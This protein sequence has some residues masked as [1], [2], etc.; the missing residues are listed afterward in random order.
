[1]KNFETFKNE[2]ESLDSAQSVSSELG[3]L[4]TEVVLAEK[5]NLRS[6]QEQAWA[7]TRLREELRT[8]KTEQFAWRKF[9]LPAAGVLSMIVVLGWLL[10]SEHSL[11]TVETMGTDLYAK[12]FKSGGAEV[13]WVTGYAYIP[14]SYP[15]K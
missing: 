13:V 10:S 4:R 3:T 12:T 1:M 2:L 15:L 5:V 6:N 7:W 14:S 8:E 11:L 9:F